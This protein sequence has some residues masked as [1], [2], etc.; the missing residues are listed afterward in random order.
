M[1]QD[2][3]VSNRNW[4]HRLQRLEAAV[5]DAEKRLDRLGENGTDASRIKICRELIEEAEQAAE[6]RRG[7][8]ARPRE[9]LAWD[10]LAQ[11][12]RHMVYLLGASERAALWESLRAEADEKLGGHRKRA[13]QGL[14]QKVPAALD[15]EALW[16][17]V[18]AERSEKLDTPCEEAVHRL[19]TRAKDS[20]P[21]AELVC[22]VMRLL[23]TTSQ[24]MYHKIDQLQ[25]Q[26]TYA[27]IFL[28]V[29]VVML[30]SGAAIRIYL[31]WS[32][33]VERTLLL[34]TL[35][36][37]TGGVLSLA[38]TVTRSDASA[39]IPAM[40]TSFEVACIRPF[41]GAA[42]ALPVIL[43][44]ES[45]VINIPATDKF[46]VVAVACFLAG[47]SERWFLGLVE[48]VQNKAGDGK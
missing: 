11:F 7:W 47:F 9:Y 1:A 5:V 8:L 6:A 44:F 15:L 21:P 34:G 31:D 43:I 4:P 29:L 45:G 35:M 18:R 28:V 23:Q 19:I 32:S 26:I 48:K 27:T 10:C 13:V 40:R 30:L 14:S 46:W 38:F 24:N 39:K 16:A 20:P 42:I 37:L 33:G 25:S 3:P 22:E 17:S 36:G 41:I 2:T 12:D